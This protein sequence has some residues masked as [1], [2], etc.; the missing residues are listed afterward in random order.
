MDIFDKTK[1]SKIMSHVKGK[2]TAAE[3]FIRK[4]LHKAG[5]R[6][7]LYVKSLNGS[8]DLVFPKYNAVIFVNGCFWH[9]HSCGRTNI[10]KTNI[11]FWKEKILRNKRNDK[12][13]KLALGKK[14]W[15][16]LIVW[17]CAIFGK[18]KLKKSDLIQK[19]I[20]WLITGNPS[21]YFKGNNKK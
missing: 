18:H 12:S 6:Y 8:P 19:I 13:N 11:A 5:F 16:V 15:R 1:R 10:P 14:G 3:L 4:E 20:E 9:G 2:D 7:R 21:Q 17:E